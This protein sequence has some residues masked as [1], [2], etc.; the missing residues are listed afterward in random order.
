VIGAM[1]RPN[2]PI[3]VIVN[4]NAKGVGDEKACDALRQSIANVLPDAVVWFTDETTKVDDLIK[5]AI[6]DGATMLVGGGGDGTIN[7]VASAVVGTDRVLGVLPLGTLNH[8]A[9]DLAIPADIEAAVLLLRDGMVSPVDVGEVNDRVFLNNSGLGLYPDIVHLREIRQRHG[10]AKWPA[11]FIAAIHALRKYRMLG[12]RIT[13]DDQPLLRRTPAV[14]VGNN[15]YTTQ[16]TL[17]PK[18]V[19]LDAGKLSL[20]IPRK[21]GRWKLLWFSLRALLTNAGH[22]DAFETLLTDSFTIESRHKGL[23]VSLDGEVTVMST[24]LHYR[25]RARELRV[26]VPTVIR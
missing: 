8:F 23:R 12:I 2:G 18:R 26:I 13:V 14:L 4:R 3:R 11:M 20:Y 1:R 16:H 7:A 21:T 19:A 9:K 25:T 6:R 10:A 17:E 15:E 22:D 5:R 24:P